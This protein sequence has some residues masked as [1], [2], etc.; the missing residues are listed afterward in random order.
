VSSPPPAFETPAIRIS[1]EQFYLE[2]R[3]LHESMARIET[4][5]DSMA[6]LESRLRELENLEVEK[7]LKDH[8]D[9]LRESEAR[10]LPHQLVGL[11]ATVLGTAALMWQALRMK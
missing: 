10:R 6:G 11:L 1:L 5:L 8:E 4:K 9:R 2:V 7:K 3:S